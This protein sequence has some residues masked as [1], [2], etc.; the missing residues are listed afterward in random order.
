MGA[1]Q[2]KPSE[3]RKDNSKRLPSKKDLIN[4]PSPELLTAGISPG[5][6][7][8]RGDGSKRP[9]PPPPPPKAPK[10]EAKTVLAMYDFDG[11]NNDDLSFKKGDRL[12]LESN[13]QEGDWWIAVNQRTGKKGYIPCNYVCQDDNLWNLKTGGLSATARKQTDC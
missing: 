1:R 11:I 13:N 4:G 10:E 2:A 3:D 5:K 12:K 9:L 8:P 7:D 6:T